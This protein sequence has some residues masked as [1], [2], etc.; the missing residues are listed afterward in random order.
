MLLTI[1]ELKDLSYSAAGGE[2]Q[3]PTTTEEVVALIEYRDGTIIDAVR[4][5]VEE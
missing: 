2:P 4:R 5:V 3:M 1:E